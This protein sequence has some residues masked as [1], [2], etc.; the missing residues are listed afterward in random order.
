M[1][2]AWEEKGGVSLPL[3]SHLR[4]TEMLSKPRFPHLSLI[5]E[6][7]GAETCRPA[8][9]QSDMC[10]APCEETNPFH[11]REHRGVGKLHNMLVPRW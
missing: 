6:F 2:R 5:W 11:R 3:V 10:E 9:G 7:T 8:A 1:E 4:G